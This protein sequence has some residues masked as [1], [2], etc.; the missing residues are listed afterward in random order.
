LRFCETGFLLC[1]AEL[2]NFGIIPPR[3]SAKLGNPATERWEIIV[4]IRILSL[5]EWIEVYVRKGRY[6]DL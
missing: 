2:S 4:L 6:K 3:I 1:L 5:C